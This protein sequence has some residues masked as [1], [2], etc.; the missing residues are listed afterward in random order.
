[1]KFYRIQA[2]LWKYWYI[3]INRIDRLFDII[4]WP[5]IDLLAWGFATYFIKDISGINLL[6]MYLGGIILWVF[7]WRSSQDLTIYVLEDF[8]S[9]NLYNLFSS[10]V[11]AS[12]ILISIM[13]FAFLRAIATFLVLVILGWLLYSF[14]I[15]N[16]VSFYLPL[17]IAILV[18]IGWVL[19]MFVTGIVYIYGQRVQVFAW[20]MVWIVQPFSCVFYPLSALPPWAAAIARVNPVT[21]IFEA[22]RT[23]LAGGT[24]NVYSL[25]YSFVITIVLF[26]LSAIFLNY[27]IKIAKKKGLF[28][29]Y[30]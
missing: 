5:I 29:K 22:F 2:L 8:W 27:S 19:G 9:R 28:T 20:S 12:E 24:V 14:N 18:L 15:F 6:A 26:G 4:Y 3:S 17:F 21:H 10:P 7:V 13:F 11:L 16:I 1:M 25:V 30:D 23:V